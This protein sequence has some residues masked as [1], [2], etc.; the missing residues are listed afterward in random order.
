MSA[1]RRTISRIVKELRQVGT[2]TQNVEVKESVRRLPASLAETLSAFSNGSG[3][4]IILGLS[5]AEGFVPAKGFRAKAMAD[6]LSTTCSDKLTPPVRPEIDIVE[7]EGA[8]LVVAQVH[9]LIPRDKPCYL[10]ERGVYRGSYIR[11]ADGDRRLSTYEIDRLL[12]DRRQPT[13]DIEPVEQ[14]SLADLDQDLVSAVLAR[15]RL[16]HPRIFSALSRDDALESL[17]VITRS[18]DGSLVPTL[19]GLLALGTYP[20][21]YFPRLT[22]VFT[23]YGAGGDAL[24][25]FE[26]AETMAG[27]IPAQVQD[28]LAALRRNMRTAGHLSGDTLLRSEAYDYPLA[29]VREALCNAL[30][31]R[32]LSPLAR[33]TAVQVVLYPD[34]LQITSP[35]GLYGTATVETL[36]QLGLSSARNQFLASLLESVP[37]N[38]GFLVENRGTGYRLI[39][40]ELRR[41]GMGDP[42][43]HDSISMFSLVMR[44]ASGSPTQGAQ[45]GDE[46]FSLL[47]TLG[48]ASAAQLA[49]QAR[50]ARSTVLYRLR[51]LEKDGLVERIGTP[52]S[53]KQRWRVRRPE[54]AT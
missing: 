47:D 25:K 13:F 38:D 52:H 51:K 1:D 7:Y 31:H 26:D 42:E 8:Q 39:Q 18:D 12:E 48:E 16:L 29:A 40:D 35:G 15:Q 5:E 3:G 54:S 27:P 44:R 17:R 30:M 36:G 21:K 49:E 43:P 6:A 24:A 50:L 34:R 37:Y 53:P 11:V 14:A 4:T 2:D 19:G 33:G 46:V 45:S 41:A 9:E 28:T 10:T 20:Q 22:V 32:D 23:A